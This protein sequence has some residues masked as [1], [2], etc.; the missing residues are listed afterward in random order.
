MLGNEPRQTTS[1]VGHLHKPSITALIHGLNRH[2]YSL[3]ISYRKGELE[4]SMLLQIGKKNWTAGLRVEEFSKQK[5]RTDESLSEAAK[6]T[7][8]Y[9][10][11]I[12]DEIT[13]TK[14]QIAVK[15]AGKV[16]AKKRLEAES[17]SLLT[18]NILECLGTMLGTLSF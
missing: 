4:Q 1:N 14:T 15:S 6:L 17:E 7:K 9:N 8:S 10:E 18:H 12:R 5:N 13:L 16:D 2:Y 3:C 11:T